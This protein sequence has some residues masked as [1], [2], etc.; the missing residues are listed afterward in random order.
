M[1]WAI[2]FRDTAR[3]QL[4]RLAPPDSARII[5]FLEE[6]LATHENPRK[7]GLALKGTERGGLWRYR[8]GDYRIICEIQDDRLV[9]LVVEIGHRREVY[10]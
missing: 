4:G 10:R 8:V 6:R 9:V 2:D 7:L 5:R 3:K 1:A